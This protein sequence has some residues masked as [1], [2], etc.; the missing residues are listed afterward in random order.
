M[1]TERVKQRIIMAVWL[2]IGCAT[3]IILYNEDNEPRVKDYM[4]RVE[5]MK[6]QQQ[7]PPQMRQQPQQKSQVDVA[8]I[9]LP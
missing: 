9:Q 2:A 7:Q 6:A 3:A 1:K 5:A 8:M 4:A